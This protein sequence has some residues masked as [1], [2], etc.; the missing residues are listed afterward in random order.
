MTPRRAGIASKRQESPAQVRTAARRSGRNRE[1]AGFHAGFGPGEAAAR[2]HR[3]VEVGRGGEAGDPNVE[4]GGPDGR[5]RHLGY[6]QLELIDLGDKGRGAGKYFARD[7]RHVRRQG[8]TCAVAAE[9]ERI[10][11]VAE[12]VRHR[13]DDGRSRHV[14]FFIMAGLDRPR[15]AD[16]VGEPDDPVV[17]QRRIELRIED[18][19]EAREL[20]DR[21]EKAV[22]ARAFAH[23]AE[24]TI[25]GSSASVPIRKF[26]SP[27]NNRHC[28]RSEAIQ[29]AWCQTL[30]GLLRR[31]L[32]P[33]Q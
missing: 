25:G 18:L 21:R 6:A 33:S 13:R 11:Y 5:D 14:D 24:I 12:H 10:G 32:G 20:R 19:A 15:R 3:I 28:E 29:S 9:H 1:L 7:G 17:G 22:Y 16:H 8:K 2:E 23:G 27:G 31:P 26:V 4:A 30:S